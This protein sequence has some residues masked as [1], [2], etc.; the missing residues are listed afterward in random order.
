MI[1]LLHCCADV[2]EFAIFEDE[3]VVASGEGDEGGEGGWGEVGEDVDVR[4]EDRDVGAEFCW[5]LEGVLCYT[6][7]PFQCKTP[8]PSRGN[9]IEEE[10]RSGGPGQVGV[11]VLHMIHFFFCKPCSLLAALR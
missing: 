2:D 11:E 6:H 9:G 10:M 1:L 7:H 5:W 3:E 8:I 4:F